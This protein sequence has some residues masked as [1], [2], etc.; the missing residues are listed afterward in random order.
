[1]T[2]LR[3]MAV[4]MLFSPSTAL[5]LQ[6]HWA[7]GSANL[8]MAAAARCTLLVTADESEAALPGEWRL[9][10]VADS[11]MVSPASLPADAACAPDTADVAA[12]DDPADDL[13]AASNMSTAHFCSGSA[14]AAVA[15]YIFDFEAGAKASFKAVALSADSERRFD[16]KHV[17]ALLRGM[18]R[19][20]RIDLVHAD[21]ARELA[22]PVQR[23]LSKR[24]GRGGE[25]VAGN[26]PAPDACGTACR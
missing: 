22:L 16:S 26:R 21:A 19:R 6:M 11:C 24:C 4:L 15:R 3:L 17:C 1:M 23:G 5:A 10:W 8:D 14:Q 12:Y 7:S 20:E 13:A 18:E 25:R 2:S 9:V